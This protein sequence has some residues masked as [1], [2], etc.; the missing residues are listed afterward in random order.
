MQTTDQQCFAQS[1]DLDALLDDEQMLAWIGGKKRKSR[2]WL[3]NQ[4]REGKIP[5][6]Q[7]GKGA[8]RF[9]PR[10]VLAKCGGKF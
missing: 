4:V 10:T 5:A 3:M 7:L 1:F 6:V 9:H 8:L 2:R